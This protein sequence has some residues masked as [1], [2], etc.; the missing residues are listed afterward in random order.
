[1]PALRA[2]EDLVVLLRE[3]VTT[4]IEAAG[5]TWYGPNRVSTGP[6]CWHRDDP[7]GRCLTIQ[8]IIDEHAGWCWVQATEAARF[9]NRARRWLRIQFERLRL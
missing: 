2:D 5:H 4:T 9:R 3:V 6:G 8:G 1:M 7:G